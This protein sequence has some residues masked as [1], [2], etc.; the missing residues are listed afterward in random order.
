MVVSAFALSASIVGAQV[1]PV[2][3]LQFATNGLTNPLSANMSDAVIARLLIDT[4]GSSEGVR[5]SSLP[6]NLITGGG[7]SAS[8]L[9]DCYVVNENDVNDRLNNAGTGSLS[10]GM[11]SINLDSPLV[12]A[13]GALTTLSLR[14][15]ISSNLV[16]GGTYTI[17]MNTANVVATGVS[18]G[19]SALV[20]VRGSIVIPPIVVNPPVTTPSFPV[21]GATGQAAQTS[22]MIIASLLIASLGFSYLSLKK[23]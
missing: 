23:N 9:N 20:T 3:A 5:I 6:F 10:N 19:M 14:C 15:D 11:N 17:N 2:V 7:A 21:T 12:L 8:T 18:T 13:A 22:A 1:A 16:A 4:T